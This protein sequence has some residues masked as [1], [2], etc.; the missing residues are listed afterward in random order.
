MSI[1]NE[2]NL[3]K[4]LNS[5][6]YVNNNAEFTIIYDPDIY[7][8]AFSEDSL[9]NEGTNFI[10]IEKL[11]RFI[12]E[13]LNIQL[14]CSKSGWDGYDAQ[15]INKKVIS[16]AF[17]LINIISSLNKK[18]LTPDLS[19]APNGSI[20]FE[21]RS[22]DIILTISVMGE[23]RLIYTFINENKTIAKR[24]IIKNQLSAE[25]KDLLLKYFLSI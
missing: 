22:D 16:E 15:P 14:D 18:I 17:N 8:K 11:E 6:T 23:E 12:D 4:A 1:V 24:E 13:L 19:P 20:I 21:W 3:D 25:I 5:A 10:E 2:Y 9:P 7:K